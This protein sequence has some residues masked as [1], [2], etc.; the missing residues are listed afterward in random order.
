ME[1]INYSDLRPNDGETLYRDDITNFCIVYNCNYGFEYMN[2][3]YEDYIYTVSLHPRLKIYLDIHINP[4]ENKLTPICD[5]H[6]NHILDVI[7]NHYGG[8]IP[9]LQEVQRGYDRMNIDS[10][11]I[12][13]EYGKDD[14][15]SA[16]GVK[17]GDIP[18]L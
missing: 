11:N 5:E 16:M 10:D 13:S 17:E 4:D 14:I 7:Q 18:I 9:F 8:Y 15:I 1:F 2:T 3:I 6:R 12:Y